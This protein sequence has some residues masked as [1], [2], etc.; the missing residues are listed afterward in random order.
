LYLSVSTQ[1]I[2]EGAMLETVRFPASTKLGEKSGMQKKKYEGIIIYLL[3]YY[4]STELNLFNF[5]FNYDLS[6]CAAL[7]VRA[8]QI[9]TALPGGTPPRTPPDHPNPM[10]VRRAA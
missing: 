7:N 9:T 4:F 3:N 10:D 5:L 8:A 1:L 6:C 2:K